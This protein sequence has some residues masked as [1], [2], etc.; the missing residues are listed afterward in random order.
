MSAKSIIIKSYH[1]LVSEVKESSQEALRL[2]KIVAKRNKTLA[3]LLYLDM[4]SK[5]LLSDEPL[6]FKE[7]QAKR[8]RKETIDLPLKLI[9][10]ILQVSH[11]TAQDYQRTKK[12]LYYI[13]KWFDAKMDAIRCSIHALQNFSDEELREFYA[14]GRV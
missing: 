9:M 6:D 12:A 7:F 2:F 8:G 3:K 11:R 14:H 1:D 4:A 10:G 13:Q 5:N